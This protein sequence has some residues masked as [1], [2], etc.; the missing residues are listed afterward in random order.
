LDLKPTKLTL[1]LRDGTHVELC[2]GVPETSIPALSDA[3]RAA[4][5]DARTYCG[6]PLFP[7]A[8]AQHSVRPI[9]AWNVEAT[10]HA[11][12]GMVRWRE[13]AQV[14]GESADAW[15]RRVA[16]YL[17]AKFDEAVHAA[18]RKGRR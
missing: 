15:L 6:T 5:H 9:N 14:G 18:K 3:V 1:R 13:R 12:M 8:P 10:V 17:A 16:P 7:L 11:P 4:I 2:V